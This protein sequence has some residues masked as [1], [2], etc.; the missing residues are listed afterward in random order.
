[1]DKFEVCF[2]IEYCHSTCRMRKFVSI[3]TPVQ[4]YIIYKS[5]LSLYNQ[6]Q[7]ASR[8]SPVG[9]TEQYLFQFFLLRS[10]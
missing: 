8:R 10:T 1:M 3:R 5:P 9:V 2:C 4:K 7:R 6:Y